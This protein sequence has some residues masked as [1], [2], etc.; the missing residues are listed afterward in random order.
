[1]RFHLFWLVF[2]GKNQFSQAK[3]P[4]VMNSFNQFVISCLEGEEM[5]RPSQQWTLE[6][7]EAMIGQCHQIC[8]EL[9]PASQTAD[10]L[11]W[12]SDFISSL[13][14]INLTC[15]LEVWWWGAHSNNWSLKLDNEFSADVYGDDMKILNLKGLYMEHFRRLY[16]LLLSGPKLVKLRNNELVILC[17]YN[18]VENHLV[19]N[20]KLYP[21]RI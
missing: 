12:S 6:H 14:P 11:R 16:S 5:W 19:A 13:T 18:R 15:R 21:I 9:G 17:W 10:W 20:Y 1:M 4:D 2:N 3:E 8:Q 7:Y